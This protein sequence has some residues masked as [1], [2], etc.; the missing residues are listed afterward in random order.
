MVRSCCYHT[1]QVV[2]SAGA[3]WE[4]FH[5]GKNL[6]NMCCL[7]SLF[8]SLQTQKDSN[9]GTH[10]LYNFSSRLR[11]GKINVL[12]VGEVVFVQVWSCGVFFLNTLKLF[13]L[14]IQS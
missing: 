12:G 13:F 11:M 3:L 5:W 8:L 9:H 2:P 6:V 10:S 7:C 1:S 14:E 4:Q